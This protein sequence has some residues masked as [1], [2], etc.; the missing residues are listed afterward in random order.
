MSLLSL[1]NELIECIADN[2]EYDSEISALS[3]TSRRLVWLSDSYLYRQSALRDTSAALEWAIAHGQENTVKRLLEAGADANGPAPDN[4]N[5]LFNDRYNYNTLL[6]LAARFGYVR[7]VR[8]LLEYG[9]KPQPADDADPDENGSHSERGTM[10]W[11]AQYGHLDVMQLLV[12]KGANPDYYARGPWTKSPLSFAAEHGQVEALEFLMEK[13]CKFDEPQGEFRQ[14]PLSWA[15]QN[16]QL[17]VVRLLVNAGADMGF[18]IR[19]HQLP[20][21][22]DITP[23]HVAVARFLIEQ[24]PDVNNFLSFHAH[25]LLLQ[26]AECRCPTIIEELLDH[27]D[28]E[29]KIA[30]GDRDI[31]RILNLAAVFGLEGKLKHMLDQGADPTHK[32][33][34][35]AS[36]YEKFTPLFWAAKRGHISIV[37][38][39]LD[40]GID[41]YPE[42]GLG[43][44]ILFA[45]AS[46][47]SPEVL[48]LLLDENAGIDL[49]KVEVKDEG[50][51][52]PAA[53]SGSE[54]C[55][56]IL[57]ER[58]LRPEIQFIDSIFS[59][60]SPLISAVDSGNPAVVKLLLDHGA[61]AKFE[62]TWSM[63]I[64]STVTP[65]S[66]AV[67]RGYQTIVEMLV[68]HEPPDAYEAGLALSEAAIEANV[69]ALQL[70]L[71]RGFDAN[72]ICPCSSQSGRSLLQLL[73]VQFK[74]QPNFEAALEL[75]LRRGGNPNF[76]EDLG[77][78]TP[79]EFATSHVGRAGVR[80][81]LEYGGDPLIEVNGYTIFAMAATN[82]STELM[83][84]FLDYAVAHGWKG[85]YTQSAM[86]LANKCIPKGPVKLLR[87]HYWRY[88]WP[89][90][91]L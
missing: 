42:D 47:G 81:L 80:I 48:Q 60:I 63:K 73:T 58:G 4:D 7:I 22:Q 15:V 44:Q 77:W 18:V 3:Q 32:G 87:Q 71:D 5:S 53:R 6:S 78:S 40:R 29:S 26:V 76:Q 34:D 33:P 52:F 50:L 91:D 90:R 39:F 28:L 75:L 41:P 56:R 27:M 85:D 49:S 57:L 89:N 74:H 38:L 12:D 67:K 17:D 88:V 8:M 30:A 51:L 1:P 20:S 10:S 84:I 55:V 54:E 35:R 36:E 19:D 79:L 21:P 9:A 14:T 65:L 86:A 13:G 37:R 2:L 23:G 43:Q 46:S 70:L 45:A 72:T 11:A 66:L 69:P 68:N 83:Q 59:N 24:H 16:G 62:V 31:P 25:L 64:L 82:W 61:N